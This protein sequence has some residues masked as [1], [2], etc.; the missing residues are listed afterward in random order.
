MFYLRQSTASQAVLIGP[1]VD[2]LDGNTV[3]S[4]LTVDAADIRLSKNGANIVGKNSGGGTHDEL[5][6][7]TITLDATDTDTVGRLQLAVHESGALPVYH[8]FQ[9]LEEVVFD[10]MFAASAALSVTVGSI[11]AGAITATAIADNAIDAGSIAT[12]AITSA[13]FAAGAIDAAAIATGAIDADA[14]AADA[15]AEIADGVW[16]EDAT[17][18]Q[19]QGTFGQAIGD[20]AADA[21]T[22]YAA[23]VTGAAGTTIAADIIAV[24][25]ETAS[26]LTDTAEIGAAGAGLSAIPWNASW[27]T[28]VQSECT[29]ALNAYDPPT[30]AE[31]VTEINSV[32][33]DIAALNDISVA[34]LLTTQ[35]TESYAANGTAPTLSQAMFAVHQVLMDFSISGTS[36]T[37]K[38]LGGSSAFVVTL[39]DGTTPTAASRD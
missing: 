9:V 21:N 11:A 13:K 8:E 1:F 2:S 38:Q 29:D 32:Q 4:G 39:N 16:D 14:L 35:M 36:Y 33:T 15:V 20:P 3:E 17:G 34:D 7:Y 19:T 10:A 26:I 22:I 23:V 25:A 24:K 37:V 28:E 31:L 5:G 6:Y 30:N 27:D 18:H 12:G